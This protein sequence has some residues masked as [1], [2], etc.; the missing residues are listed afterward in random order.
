MCRDKIRNMVSFLSFVLSFTC[1][2]LLISFTAIQRGASF[3]GATCPTS[4]KRAR[5]WTLKRLWPMVWMQSAFITCAHQLLKPLFLFF[6]VGQDEKLCPY[7]LSRQNLT[8]AD[9]IIVPY[10][11]LI[12]SKTR[13]AQN[14]DLAVGSGC[15]EES[16]YI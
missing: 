11:Y 13:Q 7:F 2:T 6:F 3:S 14:I 1:L 4:S 5:S 10:N 8:L 15:C 16:I 9:V 12:D